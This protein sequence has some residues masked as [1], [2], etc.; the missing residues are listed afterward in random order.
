MQLDL[1]F[2]F[3][4]ENS[5][6]VCGLYGPALAVWWQKIEEVSF[7]VRPLWAS[8]SF[9]AISNQT[10]TFV[11]TTSTKCRSQIQQNIQVATL[12]ILSLYTTFYFLRNIIKHSLHGT[13]FVTISITGPPTH[14][15]GARLVTVAGVW[16]RR[17]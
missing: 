2:S 15:V 1:L 6:R 9:Q 7:D 5:I 4:V 8:R 11:F 16:R 10:M 17:L 12:S 14:S 3:F 13:V